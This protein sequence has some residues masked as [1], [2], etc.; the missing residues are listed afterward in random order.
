MNYVAIFDHAPA[1]CPG[2]NKEVFELAAKQ[3]PTME[4]VGEE[5]GV[6]VTAI[7]VLLPGHTGVAIIEAPDY[8]AAAQF[9][10]RVGIDRWNDVSLY[11]SATPAEAMQI[12]AERFGLST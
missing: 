8:N 4:A 3:M 11:Q 1:Q 10:M 9:V 6:K 2:A 12:S 5:L 7:H